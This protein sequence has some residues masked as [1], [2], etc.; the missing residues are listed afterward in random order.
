MD[1]KNTTD[2]FA[3]RMNN[4]GI[5][6]FMGLSP[7][8]MRQIVHFPYSE[9]APVQFKSQI[10]N[11]VL[12]K[13]P[14]FR[15]AE[16]YCKILQRDKFVKLTPLGAL[17]KKVMV[18]LYAM[19]FILDEHL[20]SGLT[21]LSREQDCISIM[22]ARITAEHAGLVKKANGKLTLT[23][24]ALELMQPNNRQKLFQLF[25]ETFTNKFRWGYLDGHSDEPVGQTAWMFSLVMLNGLG[26]IVTTGTFFSTRYLRAIPRFR[27]TFKS[28][29]L[30]FEDGFHLCYVT[31]T[32]TRFF[33]W[34]GLATVVQ[35][36]TYYEASTNSYVRTDLV[37]EIFE[38]R[39]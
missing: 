5:H 3:S 22:S 7:N 35:L 23:K 38:F 13:I 14:L 39:L 19:K 25:F 11:E 30:S 20:E 31:R 15:I 36:G 24:K 4:K 9:S 16:E 17:P 27:D 8:Q 2:D 32:F 34:F 6:D 29:F 21:K 26:G 37:E 33:E 10:R 18:E 28:D 12:D 1:T